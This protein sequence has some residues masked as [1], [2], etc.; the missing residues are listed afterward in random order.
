MNGDEKAACSR[1]IYREHRCLTTAPTLPAPMAL[2]TRP[3][4]STARTTEPLLR[5]QGN[6]STAATLK[7]GIN[8]EELPGYS[9]NLSKAP[10]VGSMEHA[11]PE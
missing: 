3:I 5:L 11:Q 4:V 9:T 1:L 7:C 10:A 8:A 6:M 2:F